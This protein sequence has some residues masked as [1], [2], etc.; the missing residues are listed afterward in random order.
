M[1]RGNSSKSASMRE[2]RKGSSSGLGSEQVNWPLNIDRGSIEAKSL[3]QI[4]RFTETST[5]SIVFFGNQENS[6]EF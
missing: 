1:K 2:L 5:L 4:R 6:I 3:D